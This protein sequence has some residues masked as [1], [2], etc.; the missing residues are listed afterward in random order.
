MTNTDSLAI[1]RLISRLKKKGEN[2]ETLPT[3][4]Y[5]RKST[6]DES[7]VSLLSQIEACKKY[8]SECDK[9]NVIKEYSEENVSGYRMDRPGIQQLMDDIST[10]KIKVIVSYSLDR[11]SRNVSDGIALDLF[12]E[13]FG[14]IL[15][16]AT[17]D[18]ANNADGNFC[19]NILRSLAQRQPEK[20]AET[21]IG[22]GL[23]KAKF[24]EFTGGT[25]LYGY[26]VINKMYVI[27]ENEAQ[28]VKKMFEDAL[29]GLTI[30]DIIENLTRDR[31]YY[32]S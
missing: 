1:E 3:A 12:V 26:D 6:K 30:P 18:F 27:N 32:E 21:S 10:G 23:K 29:C 20:T 14:A 5:A 13:E 2:A 8:I 24:K 22:A 7:G 15:I 16:Y 4:I 31:I 17:Q 28:A 11:I 19:K 25:P 9:L